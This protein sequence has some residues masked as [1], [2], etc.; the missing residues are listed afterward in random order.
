[1]YI[2]HNDDILIITGKI[3]SNVQFMTH[4]KVQPF[5]SHSALWGITV[6]LHTQTHQSFENCFGLLFT[7]ARERLSC[8]LISNVST[9]TMLPAN[10]RFKG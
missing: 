3:Y 4:A 8:F 1:M 10:Y 9:G 2:L 7:L 6:C 5:L